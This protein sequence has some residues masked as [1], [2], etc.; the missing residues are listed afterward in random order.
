MHIHGNLMNVQPASLYE[1]SNHRAEIAERAAQTRRRLRKA[2]QALGAAALDAPT[3][4]STNPGASLLVGE[5]L[6]VRHNQSVAE[7]EYTPDA[8]S[9]QY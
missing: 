2:A 3:L 4:D 1:A 5:W 7:D 9:S 6:S 8:P